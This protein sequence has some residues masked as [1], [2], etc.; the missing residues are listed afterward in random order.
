MGV[1][2]KRLQQNMGGMTE[3]GDS[4]SKA[5]AAVGLSFDDV[6]GKSP[7]EAFNMTIQALQ[8]MQCSRCVNSCSMLRFITG[9]INHERQVTLCHMRK[10]YLR[11][12]AA[13]TNCLRRQEFQF[14]RCWHMTMPLTYLR[15]KTCEKRTSPAAMHGR[16]QAIW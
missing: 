5:F 10:R 11:L 14:Q 8:D 13:P 16:R 6:K 4:A 1:S 3:D 9:V 12:K 2:M 15:W 7:E